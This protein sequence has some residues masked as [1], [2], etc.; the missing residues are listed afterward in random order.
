MVYA[1]VPAGCREMGGPMAANIAVAA[2]GLVCFDA[3]GTQERMPAG[4]VAAASIADVARRCATVFISVPDG[5]ATLAV[6][7]Q[8]AAV[9]DRAVETVIDLSTIGPQAAT[10][11]ATLLQPAG[12]D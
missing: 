4:T 9:D 5:A 6:A 8:V 12:I 2:P 1:G 11:A 3:A 10:E 7:R